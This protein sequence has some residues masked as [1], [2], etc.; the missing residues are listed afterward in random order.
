MLYWKKPYQINWKSTHEE[1][2]VKSTHG[3]R[4]SMAL[5]ASKWWIPGTALG[6]VCCVT[7][8]TEGPKW[9]SRAEANLSPDVLPIT[10][11]SLGPLFLCQTSVASEYFERTVTPERTRGSYCDRGQQG[12]AY[13]NQRKRRRQNASQVTTL[14]TASDDNTSS[15]KASE[16]SL[17]TRNFY[18]HGQDRLNSSSLLSLKISEHLAIHEVFGHL[19]V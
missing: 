19:V 1:K 5:N 12:R 15:H 16:K 7:T 11:D 13:L 4:H 9:Q 17:F 10:D 18:Q 2:H 6:L 8:Q 14:R 3:L